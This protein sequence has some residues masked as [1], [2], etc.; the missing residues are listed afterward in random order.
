M[1]AKPSQGL[2]PLHRCKTI[3]LVRHAQGIHNV[4]GG[5]NFDAYSSEEFFDAHLTPLGWEQVDNLH[6]HVK[7]S[8]ISNRIELVV[9]STLL[10]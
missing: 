7:T 1:E 5:K 9:V 6:R 2:Y 3:H 10:R 4:D 8:G